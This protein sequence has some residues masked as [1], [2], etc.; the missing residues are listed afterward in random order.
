MRALAG[1]EALMVEILRDVSRVVASGALAE[2]RFDSARFVEVIR[3]HLHPAPPAR[4]VLFSQCIAELVDRE[5]VASMA[6]RFM[7]VAIE[8]SLPPRT[9]AAAAMAAYMLELELSADE[10]KPDT[11]PALE[12]IFY[13]QLADVLETAHDVEVQVRELAESLRAGRISVADLSDQMPRGERVELYAQLW[14]DHLVPDQEE[15]MRRTEAVLTGD[16]VPAVLSSD[17]VV[18]LM[19]VFTA[20]STKT[21]GRTEI[22]QQLIDDE[23]L[24]EVQ[25]RLDRQ[26]QEPGVPE[27]QRRAALQLRMAL[28]T[29]PLWL[30]VVALRHG[31]PAESLEDEESFVNRLARREPPWRSTDLEPYQAFLAGRG[32]ATAA[33]RIARTRELLE[34]VNAAKDA[35]PV[36]AG[37]VAE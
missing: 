7:T 14:G 11:N 26:C 32:E 22:L 30:I 15:V 5:L 21:S 23:F 17:Q 12:A 34:R 9:R 16:H 13:A 18:A 35:M 6:S 27:T 28:D 33:A 2:V 19:A 1:D 10:L 37:S 31:A 4:D 20:A 8:P 3:P 24:D 25:Q 29:M 36:D